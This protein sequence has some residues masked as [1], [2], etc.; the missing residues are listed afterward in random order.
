MSERSEV[1]GPRV[2]PQRGLR[3]L[4]FWSVASG[5]AAIVPVPFLDDHLVRL[6]RRRMV[7]ELAR[8]HGIVM[9]PA[10]LH[11]LTG[12]ER[13]TGLG[14]LIVVL[15]GATFKIAV[16][17]LR[18]FFRTLL[19]WLTVKDA[20]DA[21]SQ[22]FHEGF[23]ISLGVADLQ[24]VSLLRDPDDPVDGRVR[25]LRRRV[26]AVTRE[27]DTRPIERLIRS[28]F[29]SSRGVLRRAARTLAREERQRDDERQAEILES[30]VESEEGLGTLISRL[31]S[32]LSNERPYLT[33]LER[34]FARSAGAADA[35]VPRAPRSPPGSA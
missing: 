7:A 18:R 23:L 22:T 14:C 26:E 31:G 1:A 20:S 8:A 4:T 34:R 12:T 30:E 11:H 28:A 33:E 17:V 15:I 29:R 9:G 2:P 3:R 13:R 21:A 10:E 27:L 19:F 35:S 5:L 6:S 24:A 16:K 25:A 32:L